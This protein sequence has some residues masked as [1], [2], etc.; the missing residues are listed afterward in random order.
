MESVII[1]NFGPI[2]EAEFSDIK[3]IT[4]FI[5]ESGSGKSTIMKIIALFRWLYKMLNIR[6]FLKYS[7]IKKSPFRFAFTNLLKHNGILGYLQYDTVLIYKNGSL[8]LEWDSKAKKLRGTSSF[9]PKNE[10]SLE[11]I[12]YIS[13]KRNLISNIVDNNL[14]IKR[15]MFYL[16]E[17]FSD[18]ETAVRD[19]K[20]IEILDLGVK[21]TAKRTAQGVKY[22]VVPKD[23]SHNYSINLNEASS[24]TQSVVPV[25]VIV[26][27]YS[28]YYDLV[29]SINNAIF[30]YVSKSDKLS[31]FKAVK[32]VGEF[33]NKNIH[34]I[35]EEPELSLFP[36]SQ[37]ELMDFLVSHIAD[38]KAREYKISLMMA[39]H[40]PYIVNYLN[41]LL[42]RYSSQ[43][44]DKPSISPED[45]S[46][47]RVYDGHIQNLMGKSIKSGEVLVNTMDLSEDM[48]AIYNEYAGL[49]IS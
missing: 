28:K 10:L 26:E 23:E 38:D 30:S 11:K 47:Y 1:K 40:S 29:S 33:S 2:K 31:D 18:F 39:T 35:I 34:L 14:T 9:I 20:E 42:R 49:K 43:I 25:N 21:F 32:N 7:G 45:L 37:K 3:K 13:D 4:I 15:E 48:E 36:S 17:T 16:N 19:V 41:V 22:F 5:G 24:G 46:V 44:A 8:V 12:S 27:Y 6:S